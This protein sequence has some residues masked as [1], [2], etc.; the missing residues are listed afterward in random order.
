M[1]QK[2]SKCKKEFKCINIQLATREHP[3]NLC[4]KY[5]TRAYCPFCDEQNKV[6]ICFSVSYLRESY[7]T[8]KIGNEL[9][10]G[11]A[12]REMNVKMS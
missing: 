3:C 5:G 11:I 7:P 9:L 12:M 8:E 4:N 2:C 1:I 6:N 10:V